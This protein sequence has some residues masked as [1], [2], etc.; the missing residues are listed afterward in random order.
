MGKGSCRSIE[1]VDMVDVLD[2]CSDRLVSFGGYKMA[3][4]LVVE[5][6]G[7]DAFRERFN[8]V[9]SERLKGRDLRRSQSIDAWI[10]LAEA[11]AHLLSGIERLRPFGMGNPTPVLGARNVTAVG[12][13]RTV[14]ED[15]IKMLLACGG[16]QIDAIGF[17]MAGRE[18]PEGP[19]DVL[20]H[21]QEDNYMGRNGIQLNLRD[22]ASHPYEDPSPAPVA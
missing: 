6:A 14:G 2:S 21:L 10:D 22:F 16:S 9:C 3:A 12:P 7:F 13:P 4:G 20:F 19:M 18:I 15:H 1:D 5:R 17:G 11:D 8:E